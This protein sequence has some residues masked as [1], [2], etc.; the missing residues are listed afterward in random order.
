MCINITDLKDACPKDYYPLPRIDTLIDATVGHELSSFMNGFNDYNQI[1]MH[2]DDTRKDY[3]KDNDIELHFTSVAHPQA[4]GQVEVANQIILDGLKKRFER[5]RNTW[6]DELLHI[7]WAYR[8]SCKVAAEGTSFMLAYGAEVV[9]EIT[10]G[11]P[12]VEAYEPETNEEGMRLGLDLIDEIRDEANAHSTKHQRRASLYYNKRVN[13]RFFQQGDLVLRKTEVS[14]F[15]ERGKLA[16]NWERP[17]KVKK[18]L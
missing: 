8:T 15:W 11:S 13:E 1:K 3:Y 4:N 2:Q 14:G 18:T 10:H 9:V 7:L 12:R 6:V 5:L 16:P 17:Y